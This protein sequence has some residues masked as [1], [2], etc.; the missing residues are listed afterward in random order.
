MGAKLPDL[1]AIRDTLGMSTDEAPA[2][3]E[4]VVKSWRR[5]IPYLTLI[6]LAAITWLV[7]TGLSGLKLGL[8]RGG[9]IALGSAL[10]AALVAWIL[11]KDSR[12]MPAGVLRLAPGKL[13]LTA[14]L[15]G[16]LVATPSEVRDLVLSPYG[17]LVL[18]R[19]RG[20]SIFI[21]PVRL[22]VPLTEVA[23]AVSR[24]M[25]SAGSELATAFIDETMR[26]QAKEDRRRKI[27]WWCS[28]IAAICAVLS[29]LGTM[30]LK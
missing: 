7:A 4:F 19:R 1:L 5:P 11:W 27:L 29:G 18:R 25:S 16:P 23:S 10:A 26:T 13:E 21:H 15:G 3:V 17:T 14:D 24:W 9:S 20:R 30:L 22:E 6:L 28:V 8:G 12:R 2:T